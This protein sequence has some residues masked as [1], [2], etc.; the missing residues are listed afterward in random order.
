MNGVVF[1]DKKKTGREREETFSVWTITSLLITRFFFP[2]PE[3]KARD[4]A[5]Q[6]RH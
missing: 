6:I 5:V 3:M 1:Y 2:T 4:Q